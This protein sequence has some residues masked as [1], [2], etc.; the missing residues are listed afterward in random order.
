M[1]GFAAYPYSTQDKMMM[2]AV[3]EGQQHYFHTQ[4][5][6]DQ[7]GL[8]RNDFGLI[9][10]GILKETTTPM[11]AKVHSSIL[12][13]VKELEVESRDTSAAVHEQAEQEDGIPKYSAQPT[14]L[15]MH[16]GPTEDEKRVK[17]NSL[18]DDT[19]VVKDK[20]IIVQHD[21]A[22]ADSAHRIVNEVFSSSSQAFYFSFKT[23][24]FTFFFNKKCVDLPF[25]LQV[26]TSQLTFALFCAGEQRLA[27]W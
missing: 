19:I 15:D 20:P 7:I 26:A 22:P 4:Q 17:F 8:E 9:G 13:A 12:E 1:P 21:E 10:I 25:A 2:A 27:S 14:V 16:Y 24:V 5:S 18:K 3:E 6:C 23:C 11:S